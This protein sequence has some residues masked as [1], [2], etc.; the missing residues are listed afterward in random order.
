MDPPH[1]TYELS[2][3]LFKPE[4][5]VLRDGLHPPETQLYRC[6][7]ILESGR[8][9][10]TLECEYIASNLGITTIASTV[11]TL[12]SF[13]G[14]EK[15]SELKVAPFELFPSPAVVG[16]MLE[17]RGRRYIDTCRKGKQYI[18]KGRDMV[19]YWLL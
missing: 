6:R 4:T 16:A 1:I 5:L 10:T 3:L 18:N 8:Y 17:E 9:V 14:V 19:S 15:V 12:R 2:W 11:L 7:N 13:E